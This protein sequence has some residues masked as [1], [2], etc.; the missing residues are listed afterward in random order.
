MNEVTSQ[1]IVVGHSATDTDPVSQILRQLDCSHRVERDLG[2][3]LT[4]LN[5]FTN[6][7]A[8]TSSAPTNGEAAAGHDPQLIVLAGPLQEWIDSGAID[9][10][11]SRC[12]GTP[13]LTACN[14]ASVS[15]A[16]QIMRRGATD[17]VLLSQSVEQQSGAIESALTQGKKSLLAEVERRQ[18]SERL[19]TLTKAEH[20]VLEAMLSGMAN[21]Q[22]AQLLEIGLRTVEL[23][24]SKIMRK[25]KAQSLAELIKFVCIAKGMVSV[26]SQAVTNSN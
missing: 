3:W 8:P 18:L 9:K 5:G 6:G 20:E 26:N 4:T 14:S 21:K 10:V 12:P 7:S 22:I 13:V 19:Q 23:R 17:V 1:A 25:M 16:V 24:R 15:E 11:Q 2:G